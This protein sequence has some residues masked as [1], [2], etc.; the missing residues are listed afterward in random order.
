MR[1]QKENNEADCLGIQ[2]L[3]CLSINDPFHTVYS[4]LS[5]KERIPRSNDWRK[6]NE[7]NVDDDESS[8]LSLESQRNPD[9][10]SEYSLKVFPND[11]EYIILPAIHAFAIWPMDRI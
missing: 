2:R 3:A 8:V 11:E 10:Y 9:V 5:S 1:L 6:H 4:Y 7:V